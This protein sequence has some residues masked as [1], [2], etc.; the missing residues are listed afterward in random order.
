MKSYPH[1]SHAL[2]DFFLYGVMEV[3]PSLLFLFLMPRTPKKKNVIKSN[4][5]V[6]ITSLLSDTKTMMSVTINKITN[7]ISG[8][9]NINHPYQS[10]PDL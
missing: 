2:V 3:I 10:I 1:N 6:P 9:N 5:S 8:N 4:I 7:N